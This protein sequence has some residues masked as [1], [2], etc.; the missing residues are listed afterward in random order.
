MVKQALPD[1]TQRLRT[2]QK[3][4]GP[5]AR[6]LRSKR[7]A[8]QSYLTVTGGGNGGTTVGCVPGMLEGGTGAAACA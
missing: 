5:Q 6:L 8:L 2:Q 3:R 4:R 1:E 7:R